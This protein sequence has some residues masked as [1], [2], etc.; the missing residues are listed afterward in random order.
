[1]SR[2][3]FCKMLN[4]CQMMA[5]LRP[6][7]Q[8][9]Q[10]LLQRQYAKTEHL[11]V[12]RSSQG[13]KHTAESQTQVGRIGYK[14]VIDK[15]TKQ[16]SS[17]SQLLRRVLREKTALVK[18]IRYHTTVDFMLPAAMLLCCEILHDLNQ[19]WHAHLPSVNFAEISI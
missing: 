13:F 3:S 15:G 18:Q 6:N 2:V 11:C 9:F 4:L 7:R 19:L 17:R 16:L 5:Q 1:M 8:L 10:E 12:H 14:I